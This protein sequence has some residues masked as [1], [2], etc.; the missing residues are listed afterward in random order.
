MNLPHPHALSW[1]AAD[2]VTATRLLYVETS[3]ALARAHKSGRVSASKFEAA[4]RSLDELWPEFDV[5]ELGE[6]LAHRAAQLAIKCSLRG[7]DAVHCAAA[8]QLANGEGFL[9]ATGDKALLAACRELDI[10]TAD[11]NSPDFG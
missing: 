9:A 3:A 10:A 2:D 7:Y 4:Q 8:E 11:I 1:N 6:E 5:V